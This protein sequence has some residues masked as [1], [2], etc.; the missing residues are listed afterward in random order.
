MSSPSS[1]AQWCA[2]IRDSGPAANNHVTLTFSEAVLVEAIVSRGL[3]HVDDGIS[4]V[5]RFSILYQ[6]N[7]T[8]Q[9]L[10]QY[11]VSES[12]WISSSFKFILIFL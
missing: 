4:Y 10:Q 3:D 5:S 12:A 8:N 9:E 2:G 11:R 1:S 6:A 7:Q